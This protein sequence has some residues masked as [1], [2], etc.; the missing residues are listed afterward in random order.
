MGH[1]GNTSDIVYQ[2]QEYNLD[3]RSNHIYLV[4]EEGAAEDSC[5]PGVEFMMANRF[6]KNLNILMCKGD[7][8]ILVH[9]KTCF[10]RKTPIVTSEGTKPIKNVSVGDLVLTHTGEYK[11][12]VETMSQMYSG[13]MVRIFYG[14]TR[15]H[16]TSI[17]A[18]KEHPILVERS[19]I[20]QW[21]PVGDIIEGDVVFVERDFC[22]KTGEVIPFWKTVK[23][24]DASR[25]RRIGKPRKADFDIVSTCKDLQKQ[26][27]VVVPTDTNVRPDIVGFKDGKVVVFEVEK[28]VGKSLAVKKE[29]YN[30]ALINDFVDDVVWLTQGTA[31]HGYCWYEPD[32]ESPFV[33][34]RVTGTERWHN[35]YKQRVYN[36]TVA[37]NNSYVANHVVVHN[38]GGDWMEGMAIYDAIT[39]CP[40]PV[41]ILNYTHARS[42]SSIIFCAADRRVMMPHSTYMIHQGTMGFE[43]TYKQ[44]MTEAEEGDKSLE[45]MMKIYI[46]ILK[47]TGSMKKWSRKRIR[48]FLEDK[49]AKKEEVYFT[50]EQAVK[51][52]FADAVFDDSWDWKSLVSFVE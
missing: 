20:R 52:G 26:G 46:D 48:E 24:Y 3:L 8:P 12:V 1:A 17:I 28:A 34:V 11:P 39:A 50:A 29:K 10:S 13:E 31:K 4:G 14:R 16:E 42:M 15:N 23:S 6:I 27:W 21:L 38:C 51:L 35:R 19:G 9:M 18:T 43:G 45:Q 40:N 47:N 2:I 7:Q 32:S 5:E 37:E 41:T 49:M 36:L 44:F 33:K 30:G 25:L 22:V